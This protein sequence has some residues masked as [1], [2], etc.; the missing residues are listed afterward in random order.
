MSIISPPLTRRSLMGA[1][2]ASFATA[3]CAPTILRA[4]SDAFEI[5][6]AINDIERT[7]AYS[8]F[9]TVELIRKG[10]QTRT[11]GLEVSA[12]RQGSQSLSLRRY[13]FTDPGDIRGTKLLVQENT[14]KDNSLWLMLP[15]VGKV[16]RVSSSNQSDAFAGTDFSYANLMTLDLANFDHVVTGQSGGTITLEST[17]KTSGFARNIGYSRAVTVA[18]ANS[19]IPNRIEYF[20]NKGRLVKT[21]TMGGGKRSPDGKYVLQSRHMVV[22]GKGR[23]TK[24]NLSKLD[25]SPQF[26]GGHFRSQSL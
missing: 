3:L 4:A 12:A 9:A 21:Q 7:A 22:H 1:V 23:E 18:A 8:A 19:M 25:F 11:R 10:A 5:A 16:R 17:A 15:S 6:Q 2:G 13:E 26:S 20:D 14:G 24:I